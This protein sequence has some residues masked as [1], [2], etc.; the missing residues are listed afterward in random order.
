M[1]DEERPL[2][3]PL[4]PVLDEE[5]EPSSSPTDSEDESPAKRKLLGWRRNY[6]SCNPASS[7][8][9]NP[10]QRFALGTLFTPDSDLVDVPTPSA[11]Y[12][13]LITSLSLTAS[14]VLCIVVATLAATGRRKLKGEVD[15]GI[16]L[17]V[18]TSLFFALVGMVSVV[19]AREGIGIANWV[20]VGVCFTLCC[21]GD[22]VLIG[23]VLV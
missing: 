9:Y 11:S 17:G 6:G 21:I 18:V 10:K 8:G 4:T 16:V 23:W 7:N 3:T 20:V 22:G 15:A 2:I 12:R 13:L 5:E 1:T 14:A 19:T